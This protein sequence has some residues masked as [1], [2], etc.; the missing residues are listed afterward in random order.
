MNRFWKLVFKIFFI[1]AL[2]LAVLW[3]SKVAAKS[4]FIRLLAVEFGYL[5]IFLSSVANALNPFVQFPMAAFIP[6]FTD[7][8]LD[9]WM[10]IFI[11]TFAMFI[12]DVVVFVL[13]KMGGKYMYN[14]RF[15]DKDTYLKNFYKEHHWAPPLALFFFESVVPLPNELVIIPLAFKGYR[16]IPLMPAMLFG[17]LVFN[18]LAA[19]G[20]MAITQFL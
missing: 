14:R 8:G 19:E 11:I 7:I 9:K 10:I 15:K 18:T 20:F 3:S 2:V 1:V 4:E 13:V 6:F 12:V 5:G 16:L 17:N